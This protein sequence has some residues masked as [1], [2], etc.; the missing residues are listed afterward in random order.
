MSPQPITPILLKIIVNYMTYTIIYY[1]IQSYICHIICI[2]VWGVITIIKSREIFATHLFFAAM[3]AN[4]D[5]SL[6][7]NNYVSEVGCCP[8]ILTIYEVE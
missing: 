8:S 4:N 7:H 1:N 3:N 5:V 2:R 6:V